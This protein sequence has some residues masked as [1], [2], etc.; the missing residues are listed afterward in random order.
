M[1]TFIATASRKGDY[2]D[3]VRSSAPKVM[4]AA[5]IIKPPKNIQIALT[6]HRKVYVLYRRIERFEAPHIP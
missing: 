2:T 6:I 5:I 4:P 3:I 1:V